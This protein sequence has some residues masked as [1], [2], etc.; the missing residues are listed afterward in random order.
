[1][2]NW[3]A[4]IKMKNI[5]NFIG[6]IIEKDGVIAECV[7]VDSYTKRD[8]TIAEATSWVLT[9]KITGVSTVRKISSKMRF[10]DIPLYFRNEKKKA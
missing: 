10:A 5:N 6:M 7:G 2:G 1:M 4:T 9:S 3:N 8:G